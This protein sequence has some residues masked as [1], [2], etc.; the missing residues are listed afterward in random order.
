[1]DHQTVVP[2]LKSSP[3][4]RLL[5]S[6]P[7]IIS[8]WTG[9]MVPNLVL[10]PMNHIHGFQSPRSH[11]WV[12][13]LHLDGSGKLQSSNDLHGQTTSIPNLHLAG[14]ETGSNP[15]LTYQSQIC[16]PSPGT[17]HRVR[18]LAS[19]SLRL[20]PPTANHT[21]RDGPYS[22]HYWILCD[23]QLIGF[24]FLSPATRTTA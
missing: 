5:S 9:Q 21:Q 20:P 18:T 7:P 6:I 1:M 4:N 14:L 8:P 12:P 17:A 15:P 10:I 22:A 24:F 23:H 19:S 16:P 3:W 11:T 2:I 13:I